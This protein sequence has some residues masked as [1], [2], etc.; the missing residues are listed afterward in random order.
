MAM[1][2]RSTKTNAISGVLAEKKETKTR[3]HICDREISEQEI[4]NGCSKEDC[5]FKKK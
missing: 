5:P 4:E 1:I 3:C 2:K